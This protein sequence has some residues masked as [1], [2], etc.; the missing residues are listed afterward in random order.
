MSESRINLE[1]TRHVARLSKLRYSEDD[2]VK[3]NQEM[4]LIL[5]T[6]SN[7]EKVPIEGLE[8]TLSVGAYANRFREDQIGECLPIELALSNAGSSRDGCFEIPRI[9]SKTNE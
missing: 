4:G 8:A 3:L 6:V 7:L 9:L 5:D 2:L 1:Q